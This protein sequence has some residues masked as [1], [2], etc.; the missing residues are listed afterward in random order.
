[1]VINPVKL[2]AQVSF[3]PQPPY[4]ATFYYMWYKNPKTDGAWDYWTDHGGSP[5]NTWF[6][7]YIPDPNPNSFDPANELYSENNYDIFKWQAGKLKEAK[8]EVAIASWWGQNT[9]EDVTFN[10]IINSFMSRPDNPYPNLRWAVYYEDEGFSDPPVSI[11]ISDLTYIKNKYTASPYMLRVGGKPVVF[12][13]AGANDNPGTMT[14]RWKDANSA[15]G[16]YFYTVLK[17]FPGSTSD[18]N[19]PSAWHQ[20]APAS[21]S[22]TDNKDYFFVSPG[23]WLDDGSAER[24]PRNL[25]DFT[26]AV[27]N[28]V[29]S[30]T[31][32]K[33][34]ETWNEWGEG[35]SVEPGQQ[36][37]TVNG[38]DEIDPNGYSFQNKYVD[39]LNANLPQ[40]EQGGSTPPPLTGDANGDGKV[41][42][43]DIGIVIDNYGASPILNLKADINNDAH[44]DIIDIGIIIDNYGK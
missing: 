7:H 24:L 30:N 18:L 40:L 21:R 35:T 41:D 26:S 38:K 42:I 22:G 25:T 11:L 6:S 4:Y 3:Q 5:P 17:V 13:Y 15:L 39:T 36:I 19:Q 28:M 1:M 32:W 20:Y 44:V 37:K 8:I 34:I 2:S 12:V 31:T 23:F 29:A 10:N 14:K 33:L 27:K 9:R 43:I 16:N